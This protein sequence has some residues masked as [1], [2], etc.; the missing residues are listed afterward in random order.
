LN[1]TKINDEASLEERR[2]KLKEQKEKLIL[3]RHEERK[4]ELMRASFY[5]AGQ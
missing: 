2:A 4:E 1:E 3:E 5:N